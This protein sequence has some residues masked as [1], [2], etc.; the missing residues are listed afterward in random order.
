MESTGVLWDKSARLRVLLDV[1]KPLRRVQKIKNSEGK[2]VVI[3][4]KYERLP[5][6]CYACS[7]IGHMERDCSEVSEEEGARRR[8][9]GAHG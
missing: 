3:E 5:T 7:H 6:F 9:S 1:T 8:S 2:V 4:I